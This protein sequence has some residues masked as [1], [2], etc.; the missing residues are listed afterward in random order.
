MNIKLKFGCII[1]LHIFAKIK[2]N[3]F[4]TKQKLLLCNGVKP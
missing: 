3:E 1:I 2:Y 4:T